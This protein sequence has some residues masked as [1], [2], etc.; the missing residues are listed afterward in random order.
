M[1]AT[2]TGL[3]YMLNIWESYIEPPTVKI[4]IHRINHKTGKIEPCPILTVH[5]DIDKFAQAICN[6]YRKPPSW[7]Q[8][9]TTDEQKVDSQ[10]TSSASTN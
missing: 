4:T 2:L 5:T 10:R 3:K 9:G 8:K 6:Y 7:K 1:Q